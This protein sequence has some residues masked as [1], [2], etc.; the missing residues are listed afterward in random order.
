ME[1]KEQNPRDIGKDIELLNK[2]LETLE[3]KIEEIKREREPHK[4]GF[5]DLIQELAGAVVVAF[6]MALSEE[7]WSLA[8]KISWL[9][10]LGIFLFMLITANFFISYGNRKAWAKQQI[11]GFVQ[12]RLLTTSVIAL[13]VSALVILIIGIYP[14]M[15][16]S[17]EDYLKV[18]IFVAAFSIIGGLGLDMT[19]D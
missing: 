2:H 15:V 7:I 6:T 18:V 11:F 9:H 5:D 10:V 8:Q 17:F 4:L 13:I 14:S 1:Q 3:R 19:K 12:L 16:E